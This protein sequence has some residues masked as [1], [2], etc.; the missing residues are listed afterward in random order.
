M[1]E[2]NEKVSFS[3]PKT[4]MIMVITAI[5]GGVA[6]MATGSSKSADAVQVQPVG[7]SRAE[8]QQEAGLAAQGAESRARVHTDAATSATRDDSRRDL[9]T[10]TTTLNATLLRLEGKV[11]TLGTELTTLKVDVATIKGRRR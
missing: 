6:G 9:S 1:P 11:D 7:L 4:I 8:V 10:A 2:P 5:V 3:A